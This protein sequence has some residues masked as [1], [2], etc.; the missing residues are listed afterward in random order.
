MKREILIGIVALL[1]V[2]VTFLSGCTN[3]G[4]VDKAV[5][6]ESSHWSELGGSENE[7]M[8]IKPVK[9]GDVVYSDNESI[10]T[11][12]SVN[13]NKIVFDVDGI[14]VEPTADGRIDFSKEP[15]TRITL[16]S[17]QDIQL[18]SLT[19][20]AGVHVNIIFK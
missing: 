17:G 19:M 11:V 8:V 9:R 7:P 2:L 4:P 18:V 13:E 14:L 1:G 15:L 6:V 16:E 10:I 12:R 5:I 20:D 3:S